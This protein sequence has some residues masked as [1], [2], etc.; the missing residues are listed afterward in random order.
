MSQHI[1]ESTLQDIRYGARTLFRSP[2]FSAIAALTLAVGIGCTTAA[3]S[4]LDTVVW[5]GLPYA[6]PELLETVFERSDD[7][8]LRIPSY[9]TFRDWEAQ[10]AEVSSAIAGMAFVRGDGVILPMPGGP[11]RSIAAYVTPGFFGLLGTKPLFGRDFSADEEQPGGPRVAILS[12]DYFTKQFGGDAAVVGKIVSV[13]SV[14]TTIIGV[15]PHGFAYPNFGGGGYLLGPSLWQPIAVFDATHAALKLRGL[16]VDSRAV[17]RLR[18]GVD[19]AHAATVMRTIAQRL[20][21]QYPIEQAHWSAVALIPIANEIFGGIR[22]TITL[23]TGAIGLV[24]LLACANVANLFLVRASSRSRELA[25]RVALGAGRGR[26]ARQML[27][28]V[29][30]VALAAGAL[31]LFLAVLFVGYVRS[32]ATAR[33]PFASELAVNGRVATFALLA[34]LATALLVGILPAMQA[35]SARLMDRIR[36]G[37]TAAVGGRREARARNVLVALQFALALTLLMSAGLLLQ[38]F[39]RLLEVPL[40][41]DSRDTIDFAIAPPRHRYES[42]VEAAALYARILDAVRSVPRVTGA[43]AAGGALLPVKVESDAS[44][45]GRAEETAAYHPVSTD[46]RRTM[47]IP[48]VAGRWFTDDDMRS[49]V[50]FVVSQKLAKTLWPG[51]D[52]LGK[53]VTVRRASQGRADFGQP[54]TLPVIGVVADVRENGPDDELSAELYLPYTLEVWPWMRFVV[55]AENATRALPAVDRAIRGVEPALNFLGKPSVSAVGFDAIDSQRRFVTFVV[56]GFAICALLLAAV[57]LYGTVSYSVVQRT[58]ELGV[59]IALGATPRGIVILVMRS[60]LAFVLLGGVL[61]IVGAVAAT[62]IIR[63]M[64]FQTTV[65]DVSTFVVVPALFVLIALLASYWSARRAANADPLLA[66]RGE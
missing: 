31:G 18:A 30:L 37:A 28:E 48:M 4:V 46:Y 13:D 59:R 61:G 10:S 23:I 38:S 32:A 34:S 27:T 36:A 21:I 57:G 2:A 39:R 45:G 25:V 47:R 14:P 29:L 64:L 7:G 8:S 43:A 63:S 1:L 51:S 11:E 44:S 49:P 52:P 42:P 58:R 16:H 6:H 65:T 55:R 26:I 35:G 22:Q 17:L 40:G 54:I 66:I 20:A 9:P 19:S 50:G 33:L 15:M 24:L 53:R 56:S 12:Y 3:F 5:R 41:Y 60:G 62:R